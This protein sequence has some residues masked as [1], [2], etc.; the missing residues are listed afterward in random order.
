MKDNIVTIK[1]IQRMA[2]TACGA[3]ANASCD[4]GKPYVPKSVR[5]R[6]IKEAN[7]EKSTRAIAEEL[8]LSQSTVRDAL[9][10]SGDH[11]GQ[12][13]GRDGKS[14]PAQVRVVRLRREQENEEKIG[15]ENLRSVLLMNSAAS[16]ECAVYEGPVDDEIIR[17]TERAA[18]AWNNL[19]KRLRGS[20]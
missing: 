14:Y 7:P 6:E 20:A 9:K 17:A 15:K 2:C 1:A 13:I 11:S 5:A 12:V 19:A 10:V 18:A 8:G 16:V 3:E 4:C